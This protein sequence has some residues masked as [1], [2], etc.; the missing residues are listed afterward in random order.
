MTRYRFTPQALN[1]L[2]DIW[3]YIAQ[4]SPE[5]A[6]RVEEAIYDACELLARSPLAG[7]VRKDLTSLPL[8]FWLAPQ[9]PNYFIVYD[10]EAKPLEVIRILHRA[11]NIRSIIP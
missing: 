9:F 2:F 11:R 7:T 3:S 10:P 8:R 5:A 6:D 4:D 1:D